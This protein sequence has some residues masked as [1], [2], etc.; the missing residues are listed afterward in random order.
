LA[1]IIN[2][3]SAN[4][5]RFNKK[6][7][8]VRVS[9]ARVRTSGSTYYSSKLDQA[10]ASTEKIT[11]DIAG[12]ITYQGEKLDVQSVAGGGATIGRLDGGDQAVTISGQQNKELSD[13]QG[14]PLTSKPSDILAHE[15][16]GHAIPHVVGSDTGSAIQN[17]NKVRQEVTPGHLRPEDPDNPEPE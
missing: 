11:V 5:Y 3:R 2:A 8:L 14:E 15:L 7:E 9:V 16:V 12:K 1:K 17:E 10:I 4:K 13:T 6:G